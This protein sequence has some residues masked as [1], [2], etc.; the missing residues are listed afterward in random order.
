MKRP[1]DDA[2]WRAA[3]RLHHE[4]DVCE[5]EDDGPNIISRSEDGS[6][7]G[8]FVKAWIWIRYSDV[9]AEDRECK[10]RCDCEDC[11]PELYL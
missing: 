6:E 5:I 2:L 11:R 1:T 4:E 7:S 9:I 8:A 10:P 3:N